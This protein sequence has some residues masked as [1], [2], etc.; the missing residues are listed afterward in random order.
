MRRGR[1]YEPFVRLRLAEE[2]TGRWMEIGEFLWNLKRQERKTTK[3]MQQFQ[4]E[5]TKYLV[6]EGILYQRRKT[7]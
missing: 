1:A 7:N 5:A 3:E 2:Y 4:Q 6:S